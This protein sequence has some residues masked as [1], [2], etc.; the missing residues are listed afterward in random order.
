MAQ[1]DFSI[2]PDLVMLKIFSFLNVADLL[3]VEFVCFN[4]K[5]I[6]E[7]QSLWREV[8]ELQLFENVDLEH[9]TM[10][11]KRCQKL[12]QLYLSGGLNYTCHTLNTRFL[13]SLTCR[14]LKSLTIHGFQ[15]LANL[16]NLLQ[17]ILLSP[18][19]QMLTISRSRMTEDLYQMI[20]STLSDREGWIIEISKSK[21]TNQFRFV[22]DL[23]AYS[24]RSNEYAE[25]CI[26]S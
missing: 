20:V 13:D 5:R 24:Y 7:T 21:I 3:V 17:K 2:L 25:M 16:G 8:R 19:L 23:T 26:I 10:V 9:A 14:P 15:L 12:E 4:W 22:F 11:V 18:Q 1:W 6:A